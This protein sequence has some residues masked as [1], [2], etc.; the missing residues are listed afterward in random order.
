MGTHRT[1]ERRAALL[2]ASQER[3]KSGGLALGGARMMAQ[4]LNPEVTE[5]LV[6]SI[7][8]YTATRIFH[9]PMNWPDDG[10]D[11]WA[12]LPNSTPE[13][14]A[15]VT[16]DLRRYLETGST[17]GQFAK[18]PGLRERVE[19]VEKRS[20]GNSTY[21]VIEEQGPISD[22]RMESGECWLGPDGGRD[23]V[24]IVRTGGGAW[25]TFT[26]KVER[27]TALLAAVRTVT[28]AAHPFELHARSICYITD[29]GETAHP[30]EAE[31][32]IAYGG[33]RVTSPMPGGAVTGW[34][35]RV[36]ERAERLRAAGT[37]P[38]VNEL[39]SAIRLDKARDDEYFR[40]WY[41]RLWQALRDVGEFCGD[42]TV[43]AHLE[44]LRH[45]QRWTGLTSHRNAIAH[46]ETGR[47]DYEMVADLH[48]FAVVVS[49]FIAN[50]TQTPNTARR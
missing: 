48:R 11:A 21:L 35:D 10:G 25:P 39:L 34:A 6:R 7:V 1:P 38:A 42:Q 47:V 41:L 23:G 28:K 5:F 13:Y 4:A 26:E 33:A 30:I 14:T 36:A 40:L 45:K 16:G 46:W 2:K 3:K 24:V 32:S 15:T 44:T 31:V 19:D 29:K 20:G 50:V 9:A 43:R 22:C 18:D 37:D 17:L 49:E 8:A 27:D 12:R